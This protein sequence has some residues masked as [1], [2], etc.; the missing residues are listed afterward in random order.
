MEV[1]GLQSSERVE[2]F[3]HYA[4]FAA[5]TMFCAYVL[6]AIASASLVLIMVDLSPESKRK[7][8]KLSDSGSEASIKLVFPRLP[9]YRNVRVAVLERNLF[10]SEGELPDET[11][12]NDLS[13][14]NIAPQEFNAQAP[15]VP[16]ALPLQ[17]HGTIYSSPEG[18]SLAMVQEKDFAEMDLYR[19][20][21]TL[22]GYDTA[23]VVEILPRQVVLNHDGRKECLTVKDSENFVESNRKGSSRQGDGEED[24]DEDQNEEGSQGGT[25]VLEG[26]WVE[27]Q[28]GDGFGKIIQSARLVPNNSDNRV[29][30][31][32]IYSIKSGTLFDKVG[33][34]NGDLIT[35]VNST[36]LSQES[37]FALFQA[38]LDERDIS[39]YALRG[40]QAMT[41]NV[42]IK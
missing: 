19:V 11:A 28:L 7:Q 23:T 10:N 35:K 13:E 9:N 36:P 41:I 18:S 5:M 14:N 29:Q 24:E 6:A 3:F 42:Q 8:K 25:V 15:C 4:S 12:L 27:E 31:F 30:G 32:K 21:E 37:G 22:I 26:S 40:D 20:G 17:L 39:I 38:F 1:A 33:L 34:K 2:K 16:S